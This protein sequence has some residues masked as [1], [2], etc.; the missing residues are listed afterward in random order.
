MRIERRRSAKACDG[1]VA[2]ALSAAPYRIRIC[3]FVGRVSRGILHVAVAVEETDDRENPHRGLRLLVRRRTANP[4]EATTKPMNGCDTGVP[5][6]TRVRSD[7][8]GTDWV[9]V[10]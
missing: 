7:R 2:H 1:R 6:G 10:V 9:T 8:R 4:Y 5:L 3:S